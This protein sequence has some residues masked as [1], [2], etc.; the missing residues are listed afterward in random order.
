MRPRDNRHNRNQL[1]RRFI[2]YSI[3]AWCVPFLIVII[4]Q[5]LDNTNSPDYIIKPGFGGLKCWFAS[6]T[7]LL[8]FKKK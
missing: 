1:G 2:F 5:I 7:I 6:N 8:Q 3:Y 4:G